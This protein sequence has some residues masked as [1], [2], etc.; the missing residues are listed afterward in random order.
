MIKDVRQTDREAR[1]P[2][3]EKKQI[4]NYKQFKLN[5]ILTLILRFE[6]EGTLSRGKF[7]RGQF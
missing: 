3:P 2:I 5:R 7:P 6:R 4:K 1:I